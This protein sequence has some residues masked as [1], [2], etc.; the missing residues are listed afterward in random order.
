MNVFTTGQAAKICKVSS[1]TITKWFD[2][3]LLKGYRIPKSLDRRIPEEN[4]VEFLKE[5]GMPL[6]E[7][8]EDGPSQLTPLIKQE[9]RH[10]QDN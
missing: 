10:G 9:V 8:G 5:H 2:S 3:G 4:L 6:R 7:L 1:H